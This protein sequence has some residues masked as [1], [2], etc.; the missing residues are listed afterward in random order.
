[1]KINNLSN[2]NQLLLLP[3]IGYDNIA[4]SIYFA[5]LCFG[6]EFQFKKTKY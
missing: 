5:F 6:I 2:I 4:K 1:M 3:V